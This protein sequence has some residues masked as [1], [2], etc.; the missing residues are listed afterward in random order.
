MM[1][2]YMAKEDTDK[3]AQLAATLNDEKD[4]LNTMARIATEAATKEPQKARALMYQVLNEAAN[5]DDVS[6]KLTV[7][8]N[9]AHAAVRLG[10]AALAESAI[11]TVF[12]LAHDFGK[13]MRDRSS[14]QRVIYASNGYRAMIATRLGAS[15]APQLTL[16]LIP[17]IDDDECE[18]YL[19]MAFAEAIMRPMPL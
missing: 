15:F 2:H 14:E 6:W 13:A 7:T 19:L 10:D 12:A 9:I 18:A 4:R 5:I 16:S 1:L 17:T 11:R 8:S 3:A